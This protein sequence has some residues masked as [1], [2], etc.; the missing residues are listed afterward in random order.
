MPSFGDSPASGCCD[1]W[2]EPL[3]AGTQGCGDSGRDGA[4]SCLRAPDA[5][6]VTGT[7]SGEGD[8]K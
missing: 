2:H 7:A 8:E 1:L 4:W 3:T 6:G 5:R